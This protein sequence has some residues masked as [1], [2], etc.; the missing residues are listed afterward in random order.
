MWTENPHKYN[1]INLLT[2]NPE[3]RWLYRENEMH[4]NR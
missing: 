2:Q 4:R 3:S 1:S